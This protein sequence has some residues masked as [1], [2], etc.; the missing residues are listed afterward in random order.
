MP[1]EDTEVAL[2]TS[3]QCSLDY[4][5]PMSLTSVSNEISSSQQPPGRIPCAFCLDSIFWGMTPVF[6]CMLIEMQGPWQA[7]GD[8][9]DSVSC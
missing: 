1:A 5:P 2:V 8:C 7:G 4:P 3:A 9:G 6:L